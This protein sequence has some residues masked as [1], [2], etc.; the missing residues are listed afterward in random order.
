MKVIRKVPV[1][2]NEALLH[3]SSQLIAYAD[4]INILA[5]SKVNAKEVLV[6][7]GETEMG[8]KINKDNFIT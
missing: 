1:D 5:N 7:L 6:E 3:K 2:L 8:L 4:N